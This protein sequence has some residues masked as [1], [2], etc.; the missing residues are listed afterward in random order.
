MKKGFVYL[1]SIISILVQA[2]FVPSTF[3]LDVNQQFS[4]LPR[5]HWAYPYINELTQRNILNGYEDGTFQPEKT[6]TRAEWAKMVILASGLSIDEHWRTAL[7]LQACDVNVDAWYAPYIY[8]VEPYLNAERLETEDQ[9]VLLYR[10]EEVTTREEAAVSMAKLKGVHGALNSSLPFTDTDTI[11]GDAWIY[12]VGAVESGLISGFEDNTFRAQESLTR[13]EAA[14]LL[15]RAFVTTDPQLPITVTLNG[16]PLPL[17]HSPVM[18]GGRVLV[19][20][21]PIFEALGAEVYWSGGERLII[22][23]KDDKEI[24]LQID[25]NMMVINSDYVELDVPARL[26]NGQTFVPVRAVVEAFGA[27]VDWD[28]ETLTVAITE[29]VIPKRYRSETLAKAE[30]ASSIIQDKNGNLYFLQNNQIMQLKFGIA[31]VFKDHLEFTEDG[32]VFKTEHIFKLIYDEQRD[33]IL[34]VCDYAYPYDGLSA[35]KIQSIKSG[36]VYASRESDYSRIYNLFVSL[37]GNNL[38]FY[39][40]SMGSGG[41]IYRADFLSGNIATYAHVNYDPTGSS[42]VTYMGAP[43]AINASASLLA[44][45]NDS[46]KI[47]QYDISGNRFKSVTCNSYQKQSGIECAVAKGNEFYFFESGTLYR[48]DAKGTVSPFLASEEIDFA[49]MLTINGA[50]QEFMFDHAENIIF[51]DQKDGSIRMLRKLPESEGSN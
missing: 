31:S 27:T 46:L 10:P 36:R 44:T 16:E 6:V 12:V 18:E 33:D 34:A 17:D 30:D 3:A 45:H 51:Y 38:F 13:A 24:R 7:D 47:L 22:A 11:S 26:V 2:T 19:P 50:V 41:N 32:K 15:C 42:T 8:T 39:E 20:M 25:N 9:P 49:D 35:L 5:T 43:I 14:T 40:P 23:V 1:I 21:R 28:D 37:N 4:D 48:V 29:K